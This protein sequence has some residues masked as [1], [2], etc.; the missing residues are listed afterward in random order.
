M[1]DTIESALGARVAEHPQV[2]VLLP[3]VDRALDELLSVLGDR[4]GAHGP[5]ELEHEPGADRL[6][7]RGR[8]AL[9]AVLGIVEVAVAWASTSATVPPPGCVGT[10]VPEQ[11]LLRHQHA[12]RA[13][14]AD[15]LVRRQEHRVL[16]REVPVGA[17][18]AAAFIRSARR[19]GR[20][21]VPERE[22]AV[23]VEQRA[24]PR[25]RPAD[26][27]DVR[28]GREA[29][30]LQRA[31]AWRRA[32]ARACARSMRPSSSSS[33]ITTSAM[34]VAPGQLV[35]VVLVGADEHDRPLVRGDRAPRA[36]ARVEIGRDAQVQ[37]VDQLVDRAGRAGAA[38][39]HRVVVAAADALAD[40]L[41]RVL[42]EPRGLAARC[43]RSRCGCSRRAASPRRG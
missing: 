33:M 19:A 15:E 14:A 36:V 29:A 24:S 34:T 21:E 3:R 12:G 43:P 42:A 31:V 27:G 11:A 6:D 2:R 23:T 10:R 40:D 9:F 17:V 22:R 7:D 37:D 38:E 13:R 16:V 41:A 39:D 30:D 18:L 25:P 1:N 4:L 35:P 8:A 5:L 26:A 32:R 20:R 28:R